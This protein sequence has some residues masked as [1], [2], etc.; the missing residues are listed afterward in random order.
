MKNDIMQHALKHILHQ[1]D[2]K[3][4]LVFVNLM[5]EEVRRHS[6]DE[7]TTAAVVWSLSVIASLMA[8]TVKVSSNPVLT[9]AVK[10]DVKGL[11]KALGQIGRKDR[12]NAV[13]SA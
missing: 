4:F 10:N 12:T 2:V 13:L 11:K 6:K 3:L 9:A 5:E 7:A 8:R 1:V